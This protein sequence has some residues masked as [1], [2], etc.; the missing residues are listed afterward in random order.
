L[1]L[2]IV[3]KGRFYNQYELKFLT[4]RKEKNINQP[5]NKKPKTKKPK[6]RQ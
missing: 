2:T 6:M 5:K 4:K 1:L 3:E